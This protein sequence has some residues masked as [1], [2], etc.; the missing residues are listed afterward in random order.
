MN[1]RNPKVLQE[2]RNHNC[3]LCGN[4]DGTVVAAHSNQ[5]RHGKG[6]SIKAHDAFVAYLCARCHISIDQGKGTHDLKRNMWDVAHIRS[7]PLFMH[8]L[9]E[10]GIQL[11]ENDRA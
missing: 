7:V 10:E 8:L 11:L 6:M 5:S 9:D 4:N 1:Y 2:A 3:M